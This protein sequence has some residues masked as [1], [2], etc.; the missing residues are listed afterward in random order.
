MATLPVKQSKQDQ[1]GLVII[2]NIA[3]HVPLNVKRSSS[4]PFWQR[5]IPVP[6]PGRKPGDMGLSKD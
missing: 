1:S 4:Y 3:Q 2:D 6:E 5:Q